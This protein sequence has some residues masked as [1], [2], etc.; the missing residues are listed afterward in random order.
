LHEGEVPKAQPQRRRKGATRN[1]RVDAR[2]GAR[3]S[4]TESAAAA[5]DAPAGAC[6]GGDGGLGDLD[7][8]SVKD[9]KARCA[10]KQLAQ[11][12]TKAVLIARMHAWKPGTSR[13]KRGRASQTGAAA[14]KAKVTILAGDDAPAAEGEAAEESEGAEEAELEEED[15]SDDDTTAALLAEAGA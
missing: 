5:T 14:K 3:K 12:G 10:E 15:E 13:S 1:S 8:L 4:A 11:Y 7:G 6:G 2:A 9:L